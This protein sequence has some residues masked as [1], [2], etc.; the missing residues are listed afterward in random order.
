MVP[1]EA[2]NPG[3][4]NGCSCLQYTQR[5]QQIHALTAIS[6][7]NIWSQLVPNTKLS[8]LLLPGVHISAPRNSRTPR[9]LFQLVYFRSAET[10]RNRI[11]GRELHSTPLR[12]ARKVL[13]HH[14]GRRLLQLEMLWAQQLARQTFC[15][16]RVCF[17][18]L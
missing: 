1:L 16:K 15:G 3:H 9:S 11:A 18:Y 6:F 13:T 2:F 12:L 17:L 4:V 8:D 7:A 14:H 10:T 5:V